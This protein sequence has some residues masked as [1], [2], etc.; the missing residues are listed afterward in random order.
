MSKII[1]TLKHLYEQMH[2]ALVNVRA[3]L[4]FNSN[5]MRSSKQVF[6]IFGEMRV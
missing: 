5:E 4:N 2:V 6:N 3:L 1:E